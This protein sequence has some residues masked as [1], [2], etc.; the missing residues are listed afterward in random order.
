[1]HEFDATI[2]AADRG[3]AYVAVPPEVVSA[4]GGGGRIPVQATFDGIPYRGSVVSMGGGMVIGILKAIRSEL[5]REPGDVVHVT[6]ER[7]DRKPAV[8]VPD[9]LRDAL[10]AAGLTQNFAALSHSHQR[11]YVQSIEDAKRAD[12]RTRRIEQTI[13]R[14]RA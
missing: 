11:E 4:L 1:M 14:L 10:A 5:G 13:E 8:E 9:D 6:L 7:D 3:G 12:T 2:E